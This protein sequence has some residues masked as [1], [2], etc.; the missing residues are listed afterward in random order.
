[1]GSVMDLP[2]IGA[3]D[4]G[5]QCCES[6]S[7][8]S[9]ALFELSEFA[10]RC[11]VPRLKRALGDQH[12]TL[13]ELSEVIECTERRVADLDLSPPT[14]LTLMLAEVC[15]LRCP[16][17]FL[18]PQSGGLMGEG[19]ALQAMR[20]LFE[21][22]PA[23]DS[24]SVLLFGGEPLLNWP[25][26]VHVLEA[27]AAEGDVRDGAVETSMT[28]NATLVTPEIARTL[29][30]HE[31]HV[32]V[33]LDGTP[34]THNRSRA[35]ADGSPSFDDAL[36]GALLLTEAGVP[37]EVRVTVAPEAA[38]AVSDG[39]HHLASLGLRSILVRPVDDLAWPTEDWE[40]FRA[41]MTDLADEL[42]RRAPSP[43]HVCLLGQ[44]VTTPGWGCGAAA[45]RLTVCANGDVVP[46]CTFLGS[47]ELRG[48]YTLGNVVRDPHPPILGSGLRR[49]AIA[50]TLQRP[51]TCDPECELAATCSGGC[52][53]HAARVLGSLLGLAPTVCAEARLRAELG[54]G[55]QGWAGRRGEQP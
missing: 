55:T 10:L 52:P 28:T 48:Q 13:D 45:S 15:N 46:C 47:P 29:A 50:L 5:T 19:V 21:A 6:D 32:M 53:G 23:D 1:M 18:G 7:L 38:S 4:S 39:V 11:L 26:A 37:V 51:D 17:C 41:T 12:L 16:Y 9:P 30:A 14:V 25:V 34:E 54:A 49:E 24:V 35:Y 33:S 40:V 20:L 44:R 43:T 27:C 2:P 31:T 3:G 42:R 22:A 8:A 36:Q